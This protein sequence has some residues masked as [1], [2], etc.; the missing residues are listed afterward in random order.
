[1]LNKCSVTDLKLRGKRVFCRVD[2]NVPLNDDGTV[3]DDARI[4]AVLPTI[5]Y[6]MAHGGRLILAS[7]LG[8]PKG[9][10]KP[11]FSLAPVAPHLALLLGHPVT[12]A[13]DCVGPEVEE[14]VANMSDGD[15]ILLENMRFHPEE[16]KNDPK[17]CAQLARLADVYVNDAFGTAH[18]AHASTEGIAHLLK[19]AVAGFLMVEELEYL[20]KA[21]ENPKRPF[22]A[23]LGGAKVHD[24]IPVITNLLDKVDTLLIGGGMA[25]TFLHAQGFEVGKSLLEQDQVELAAS[26]L[27]QAQAKEVDIKLP[28]DHI[29]ASEFSND[30]QI[31]T[32]DD[33]NI[34]ASYMGLD[35]G[36]KTLKLYTEAIKQAATVVWN[37]PMGVFEMD[38]FAQGTIEV[39]RAM[40]NSSAVTI[41][42]GGDSVAAV[43]KAGLN[44]AMTHMSTGGGASLELLEGKTLPGVAALTDKE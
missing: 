44:A 18:R 29:V 37:G 35:I 3:A 41:I 27:K 21:L 22:V 13:P 24:K 32:T 6:I 4:M 26:L 19:P 12:M 25:Y 33:A 11:E 31:Q 28:V 42:G 40:A 1:M 9:E 15:V 43:N 20:G 34:P 14:L 23:I 7:H 8:R 16:E 5:R 39:A 30:A 10:R 2:F 17:F 38:N 36:P